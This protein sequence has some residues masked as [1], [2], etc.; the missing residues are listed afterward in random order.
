M[1]VWCGDWPVR[2]WGVPPGQAA[3]V[4]V[5][6]RVLACT[7]A[8]RRAGVAVGLRRREA[9][10]R[11]PELVTLERDPAREA[12]AFE[13]VVAAVE[14]FAPLVEVGE[15]GLCA[16]GTRGPSR[17]H[18]GDEA[19]VAAVH[20]AVQGALR[21][22]T[23]Q[24]GRGGCRV[25]V[26]DGWFAAVWAARRSVPP[27]VV[28][29]RGSAVFLAPLPLTSLDQPD[30]VEVLW[31]LGLRT[32][33]DLAA[34]PESDV[35]G[36]FGPA[37]VHAHRLA[38]GDDDRPLDARRPPPELWARR[39]LD[40]PLERVDQAAF[41]V[42]ALADELGERLDQLGLAC[43]RL[44][45]EAETEHGESLVRLW[46]DEGALHPAAVVERAR[47]QLEGW[48]D[49]PAAVRPTGGLVN[50]ALV[51]HEV[52]PARGRQLG[53]WGSET[54]T[55]ERA[56]RSLAR[57]AALLG[58]EAVGVPEA[59]GGR[60]PGEQYRLVP[61]GVV[62]LGERT[63]GVVELPWP[64]R[65]PCWPARLV[66]PPTP[67]EVVDAEGVAVHVSGRAV[68]SAPPDRVRLEG[69]AWSAVEAWAGPWPVEERWWDDEARRRQARLQ[70]VLEGGV[71]R[72]LVLEGGTWGC[73]GTYD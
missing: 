4:L 5:A 35:L 20:R 25:G 53:F 12:R 13:P 15:P 46:R 29:P 49:G 28:A 3:A 6:N 55:A 33:G 72:L 41:V 66:D 31:Q 30:L 2:A 54:Q 65:L 71:A 37:G 50:L 9:Q 26:A 24:G 8:A 39:T 63:V 69:G 18:G 10:G 56:A 1:A 34:L 23:G 70:V 16:V 19:L 44:A 62:E 48:L 52:V 51:P 59:R 45:V 38:R 64:G 14:T 21:G 47:W 57:V 7:P 32:L 36:R 42:R 27:L 22:G 11:C 58:N 40:P 68:L 67:T 73:T 43:T 61:A 60:H 17:Y